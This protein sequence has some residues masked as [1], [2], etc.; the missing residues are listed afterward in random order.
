LERIRK[1][2][3]DFASIKEAE[4]VSAEI[5]VRILAA[6]AILVLILS[7]FA[8][9]PGGFGRA[10]KMLAWGILVAAGIF[11]AAWIAERS[12]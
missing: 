7:G 2:L 3:G 12:L 11:L 10:F 4:I 9:G 5:I 6:A 8:R 1:N